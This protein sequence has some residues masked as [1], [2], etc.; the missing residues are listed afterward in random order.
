MLRSTLATTSNPSRIVKQGHKSF[1]TGIERRVS[2][3]LFFFFFFVLLA[4]KPHSFK[5]CNR[6]TE[7]ERERDREIKAEIIKAGLNTKE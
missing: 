4:K 1:T 2:C 7:E 3:V 6:D 5:I